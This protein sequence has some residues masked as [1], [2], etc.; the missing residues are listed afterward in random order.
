[1]KF[2]GVDTQFNDDVLDGECDEDH[3]ITKI[4]V[5]NSA[6][7]IMLKRAESRRGAPIET[8]EELSKALP[9]LEIGWDNDEVEKEEETFRGRVVKLNPER[10]QVFGWAYVT[11]DPTGE[12]VVDRSGEFVEDVAVLEKAAYD[13]V[14]SSRKGGADHSR[15]EDRDEVVVKSTMIESIVFTPDKI[16]EMG[17]PSGTIPQGAWWVGFQIHDE[18]IWKSYREGTRTAFS[19]HGRGVKAKVAPDR[20]S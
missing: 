18:D 5:T 15:H 19:I 4:R 11:H 7:A 6:Y 2:T 16:K 9:R 12:V 20:T 8:L 1:M 10:Q 14:T 13:F 3:N 17:I